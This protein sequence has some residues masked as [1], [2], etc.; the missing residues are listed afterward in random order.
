MEA[1]RQRQNQDRL[2]T[3]FQPDAVEIE[4]RSVPFGAPLTLYTV[5]AMMLSFV[6]W[7]C[8]AEVDKIVTAQGKL[9]TVNPPVVIDTSAAAPI[10]TMNVEFGDRVKAGDVLATLDPTYTEADV[11]QIRGQIASLDALIARLNAESNGLQ[12][13]PKD[14]VSDKNLAMERSVFVRR[15]TEYNA[16]LRE[17]DANMRKFRVQIENNETQIMYDKKAVREY[18]VL[19]ETTER[20]VDKGANSQRELAGIRL[21]LG[22]EEKKLMTAMGLREEYAKEI[23]AI[24]AQRV[25]YEATWQSELIVQLAEATQ[26]R[27]AADQELT[28]QEH[29]NSQV[30]LR[31]PTDLPQKEF[32]VLEVADVSVGSVS[33]PGDPIFRLV[34]LDGSFEAEVEVPG[35]DISLISEGTRE[36]FELSELPK[37]SQVRIKLDSFSY[38]KHGTMDGVI[39]KISEG[40]FEKDQN[41]AAINP[42]AATMYRTRVEIID[43]NALK[44]VGKNFRLMPGMTLTAEIKVGK[45]RVVQYFLYPLLRYMD[46]WG[47]EPT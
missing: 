43:P 45:Q 18:R 9:I 29:A 26:Q 33:R 17:F 38:Q 39:R 24:E 30:E 37:G 44:K 15:K 42:L 12:F 5:V 4:T 14:A 25:A 19:R 23:E 10:R 21:Q 28:K 3:E 46:E 6:A 34:P 22:G 11:K 36:Q 27:K 8:W 47:R 7:A 32:F 1:I 41:A 35:K 16:R 31:V 20:L 13:N 40:S 2:L